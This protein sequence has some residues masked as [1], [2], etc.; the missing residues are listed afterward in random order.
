MS[1]RTEALRAQMTPEEKAM[2]V[3]GVDMWHTGPIERLG[4]PALKVTDGPNLHGRRVSALEMAAELSNESIVTRLAKSERKPVPSHLAK[5][6]YVPWDAVDDGVVWDGP[7]EY[8]VKADAKS[9]L[10]KLE[11][12][13]EKER[14]K[15]DEKGG[16]SQATLRRGQSFR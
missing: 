6:K 13:A 15:E 10:K 4:I 12:Q 2:L 16:S 3:A 11:I 7:F 5:D 14:K 8:D 9:M 1:E